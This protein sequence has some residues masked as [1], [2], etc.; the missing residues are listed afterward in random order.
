MD[1]LTEIKI[2]LHNYESINRRAPNLI[3]LGVNLYN[4]IRYEYEMILS[5]VTNGAKNYVFGVEIYVNYN[6]P[7]I[8]RVGFME[9]AVFTIREGEK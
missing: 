9:T 1:I 4:A 5:Q 8:L 3:I 7:N 6:E 2:Q